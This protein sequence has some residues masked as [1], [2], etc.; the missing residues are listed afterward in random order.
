MTGCLFFSRVYLTLHTNMDGN[1]RLGLF[2]QIIII[3]IG[4]SEDPTSMQSYIK[5]LHQS[6]ALQINKADATPGRQVWYQF[7]DT[8]LSISS[9]YFA[10][11]K[12]VH[13]N[14][15]RHGLVKEAVE[16]QWCSA[17]WFQNNADRA[18]QKTIGRFKIDNL[19]V[20]DDF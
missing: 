19:N 4:F 12:Y 6:T 3:I 11:L 2:F 1:Y 9:S 14:A 16:Y 10:R 17:A 5:T 7:W 15:V 20:K 8:Y 18:F 13:Q